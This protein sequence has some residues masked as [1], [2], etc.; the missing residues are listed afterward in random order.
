MSLPIIVA[1]IIAACLLVFVWPKLPP[2]V[3]TVS[4]I[5]LAV[6]CILVLLNAIGFPVAL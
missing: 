5:V 6:A 1:L 2:M 3:Q 4:A